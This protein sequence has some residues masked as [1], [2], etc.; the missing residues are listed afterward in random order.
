MC[1]GLSLSRYS[2]ATLPNGNINVGTFYCTADFWS[3]LG[4]A[5]IATKLD[6][7]TISLKWVRRVSFCRF[8]A[9]MV[10]GILPMDGCPSIRLYR[11]STLNDVVNKTKNQKAMLSA[12]LETI[13]Q[14]KRYA[15]RKRRYGRTILPG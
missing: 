3:S 2:C 13:A 6:A 11:G 4:A 9:R 8:G 7:T 14:Q 15:L 1:Q 10:C 5:I 12:H